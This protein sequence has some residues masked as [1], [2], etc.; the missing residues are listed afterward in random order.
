MF[1][2]EVGAKEARSAKESDSWAT[3][4]HN[5]ST[6]S[7]LQLKLGNSMKPFYEV[8]TNRQNCS[9]NIYF[10]FERKLSSILHFLLNFIRAGNYT[11]GKYWS[12]LYRKITRIFPEWV[13]SP[14]QNLIG[15]CPCPCAINDVSYFHWHTIKNSVTLLLNGNTQEMAVYSCSPVLS[16]FRRSRSLFNSQVSSPNDAKIK[17]TDFFPEE[18]QIK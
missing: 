6:S 14:L 17:Y 2:R 5:I 7:H 11:R 18:T 10:L 12:R 1:R 9:C 4:P 15:Q 3:P 13:T 16:L 8:K